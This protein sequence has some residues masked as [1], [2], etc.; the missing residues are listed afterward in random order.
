MVKLM[1]EMDLDQIRVAM[2]EISGKATKGSKLKKKFPEHYAIYEKQIKEG[3]DAGLSLYI[4][5]EIP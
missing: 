2:V 3:F 5:P 1:K 4:P